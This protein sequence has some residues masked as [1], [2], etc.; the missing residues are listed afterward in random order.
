MNYLS[1]LIE[2]SLSYILNVV[3]IRIYPSSLS[4][5]F[6]LFQDH[7]LLLAIPF[8]NVFV[9]D[10]KVPPS[11]VSMTREKCREEYLPGRPL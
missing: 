7:H 3:Y 2:I 8:Y 9:S 1:P 10:K 6:C 11:I 4:F 5:N